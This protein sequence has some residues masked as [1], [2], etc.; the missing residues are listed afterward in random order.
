MFTNVNEMFRNFAIDLFNYKDWE[1]LD[2]SRNLP[3]LEHWITTL[4][5]VGDCLESET[6]A[7]I[8]KLCKSLI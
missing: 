2:K 4:Y 7:Q 5:R 1:S 6:L 3:Y 8:I